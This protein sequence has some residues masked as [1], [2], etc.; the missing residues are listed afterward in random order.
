MHAKMGRPATP[1]QYDA[2]RIPHAPATYLTS[3]E[4]QVRT[5][6]FGSV[7]PWRALPRKRVGAAQLHGGLQVSQHEL[8]Q[9]VV[10]LRHGPSPNCE[11]ST[12]NDSTEKLSL[13][14]S[15]YAS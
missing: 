1:L 9:Q 14:L 8:A 13:V 10:V 4:G 12:S 3:L 5:C 15:M 6:M 7:L 2:P 11:T